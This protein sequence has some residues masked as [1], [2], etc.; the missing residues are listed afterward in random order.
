MKRW[1]IPMGRPG[2]P[3]PSK[4]AYKSYEQANRHMWSLWKS[5]RQG[6]HKFK[7]R[8]YLCPCGAYHVGHSKGK[9]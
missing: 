6:Q 3:T 9:K 4:K 5:R 2:C 8:P 1:M 7:V